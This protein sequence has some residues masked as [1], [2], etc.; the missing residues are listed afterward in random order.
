MTKVPEASKLANRLPMRK[1]DQSNPF[2]LS[3]QRERK[4]R[5]LHPVGLHSSP[6]K[7]V[8]HSLTMIHLKSLRSK[9]L[10]S[11]PLPSL[12]RIVEG[13]PVRNFSLI[14]TDN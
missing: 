8:K 7:R 11:S 2:F 10:N 5:R 4:K 14:L 3:N 13:P 9:K 1:Q 12:T 6:Q